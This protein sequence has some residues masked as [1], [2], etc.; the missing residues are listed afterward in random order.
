MSEASKKKACELFYSPSC[1]S[2]RTS[3]IYIHRAGCTYASQANK[4]KNNTDEML[5][6]ARPKTTHPCLPV[7]TCSPLLNYAHMS[8]PRTLR[9]SR[10]SPM[11]CPLGSCH[12]R[13]PVPARC[14]RLTFS[15]FTACSL[16]YLTTRRCLAA[17]AAACVGCSR[18]APV[19]LHPPPPAGGIRLP[20]P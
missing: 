12:A 10:V 11:L 3:Q 13:P 1:F 4:I 19:C 15:V 9:F 16:V 20:A 6:H 18:P 17:A 2:A 14:R 8:P 5:I 7:T